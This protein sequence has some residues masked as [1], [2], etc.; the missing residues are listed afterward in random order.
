MLKRLAEA[1][2]SAISQLKIQYRMHEDICVL[3]S[4]AIYAGTFHLEI[5]LLTSFAIR[6]SERWHSVGT[7]LCAHK[8]PLMDLPAFPKALA[9]SAPWIRDVI[10]PFRPVVFADTDKI[11]LGERPQEQDVIDPLERTGS[12]DMGGGNMVNDTEARLIRLLLQ[13]LVDS[14]VSPLNIG[15]ICPFNSQVGAVLFDDEPCC[16]MASVPFYHDLIRAP[17]RFALLKIAS[18]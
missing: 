15:V 7:L 8:V 1:H 12:R 13:G 16:C 18:T 17:S 5:A 14:G 4:K 11:V 2:P 6:V 3:A 10:N 9:R